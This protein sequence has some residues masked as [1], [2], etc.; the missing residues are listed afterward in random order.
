MQVQRLALVGGEREVA[1]DH[2]AL[3][4]RRV[5]GEAELGRDGALVHL[6][7]ARE[8]RLLAVDARR[9]RPATA[10]YWSARRIRPGETTGRPSSVKPAAPASASSPISVSSPPAWPFEIAARKPTGTTASARACSTSDAEHRGRVDDRI[11]VRHREDRAVAAGGGR[12][13]AGRDRLLVLAAGRAQVDV[14]VDEGGREHEPGR[15]DRA[16]LDGRGDHAV[17][18]RDGRA[19]SSMPARRIEDA[20]AA[21]DE[22]VR[23]S[24]CLQSRAITPPPARPRSARRPARA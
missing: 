14:R 17:L 5:A 2:H 10:L 6:A 13:G 16:V 18:D 9:G 22:V 23:R 4:D 20:R 1:L 21:I 24:R 3:G 15:V 11:G 12:R 8:R 7:A 19:P